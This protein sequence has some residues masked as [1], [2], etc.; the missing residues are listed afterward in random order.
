MKC[1]LFDPKQSG[2]NNTSGGNWKNEASENDN[3]DNDLN[4]FGFSDKPKTQLY[5]FEILSINI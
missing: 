2:I 1:F 3:I 4:E 5:K